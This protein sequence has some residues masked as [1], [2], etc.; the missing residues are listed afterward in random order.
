MKENESLYYLYG[1]ASSIP[2][3]KQYM[4]CGSRSKT[5]QDYVKSMLGT[6]FVNRDKATLSETLRYLT[7]RYMSDISLLK[8]VYGV[9]LDS[10]YVKEFNTDHWEYLVKIQKRVGLWKIEI[11]YQYYLEYL[12]GN[13][14]SID[15]IVKLIV[16]QNAESQINN[17][18]FV[19]TKKYQK[20][21]C[22][23]I[24]SYIDAYKEHEAYRNLVL[25]FFSLMVKHCHLKEKE[26]LQ[27]KRFFNQ[28]D[29]TDSKCRYILKEVIKSNYNEAHDLFWKTN[30]IKGNDILMWY[31]KHRPDQLKQNADKIYDV[32][33]DH[34]HGTFLHRL[35]RFLDEDLTETLQILTV[36]LINGKDLKEKKKHITLLSVLSPELFFQ[37]IPTALPSLDGKIDLEESADKIN[38]QRAF[39]DGL[40]YTQNPSRAFPWLLKFCVGDYLKFA[41]PSLY[42][43]AYNTAE[44]SLEQYLKEIYNTPLSVRK[45]RLLLGRHLFPFDDFYNLLKC[46]SNTEK[47]LSLRNIILAKSVEYFVENLSENLW[48]LT[49]QNLELL[50]PADVRVCDSLLKLVNIPLDY[51]P[52]YIEPVYDIIRISSDSATRRKMFDLIAAIP[53]RSIAK[54]DVKF[55]KLLTRVMQTSFYWKCVFLLDE[56]KQSEL[57][58]ES[59]AKLKDFAKTHESDLTRRFYIRTQISNFFLDFVKSAIQFKKSGNLIERFMTNWQ[60]LFE[61]E[62]YHKDFLLVQ[63]TNVLFKTAF[64]PYQTGVSTNDLFHKYVKT[65]SSSFIDVFCGQLRKF[66]SVASL[67]DN[68]LFKFLDGFFY[69]KKDENIY[70]AMI[71]FLPKTLPTAENRYKKYLPIFEAIENCHFVAVQYHFNIYLCNL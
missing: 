26:C 25:E 30:S 46:W 59:F 36:D 68:D 19:N 11:F 57:F 14:K 60:S 52:E 53:I 61:P 49:K 23:K 71:Y 22:D 55:L 41:L 31:A 33:N 16:Q 58:E 63:F 50:H 13:N 29:I 42:S 32:M 56:T 20:I 17:F 8:T 1:T 51:M 37:L 54:F 27:Y 65:Y 6:C 48:I 45:H 3:F 28:L 15:E 7:H 39:V 9:C 43:I 40:R 38:V 18:A 64:D 24:A 70:V 21:Y 2:K 4:Q 12:F 66:L 44:L 10:N 62:N 47:N 34:K 69:E 5:K 67:E 35:K